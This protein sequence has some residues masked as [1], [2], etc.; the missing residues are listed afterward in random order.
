MPKNGDYHRQLKRNLALT[1]YQFV[2]TELDLAI[3]FCEIALSAEGKDK[4]Q[5]NAGHAER[6]YQAAT[7]FLDRSTLS[8]E[9]HREIE[10]RISTLQVLLDQLPDKT[11]GLKSQAT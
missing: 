8:E 10:D 2:V 1:R 11:N 3:T 7:R 6:A 9:M 5:R 4:L